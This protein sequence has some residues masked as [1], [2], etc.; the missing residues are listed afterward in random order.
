MQM[1]NEKY[2]PQIKRPQVEA[3]QPLNIKIIDV[4]G[5][6]HAPGVCVDLV[7][8]NNYDL[9]LLL[10]MVQVHLRGPYPPGGQI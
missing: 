3:D 7:F 9:H 6:E 4:S 1:T 2:F 10:L 8:M 5:S